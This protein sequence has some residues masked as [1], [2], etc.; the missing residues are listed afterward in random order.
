MVLGISGL[1]EF[2]GRRW[3]VEPLHRESAILYRHRDLGNDSR[4]GSR[5]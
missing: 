4:D 3:K 5:S 1:K 2:Y